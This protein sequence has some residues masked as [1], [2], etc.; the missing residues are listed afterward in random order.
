MYVKMPFRASGGCWRSAGAMKFFL[1][2]QRRIHYAVRI[3]KRKE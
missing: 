2:G 3:R 1:E